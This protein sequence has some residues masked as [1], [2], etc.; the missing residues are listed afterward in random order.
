M[1]SGNCDGPA[2]KVLSIK[3]FCSTISILARLVLQDAV[4]NI[5]NLSVEHGSLTLTL[6]RYCHDR[7]QRKKQFLQPHD[8][9]P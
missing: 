6:R 5:S 8:R 1:V 3:L 4:L 2:T 9:N 7:C